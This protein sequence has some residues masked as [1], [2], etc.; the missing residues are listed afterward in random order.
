MKVKLYN[1]ISLDGFIGTNN[2]DV[3]WVSEVDVPYFNAEM[4]RAGCIVIGRKTFE[5]F[6]GNI[7]PVKG[8]L[9]IVMTTATLA[10]S[11]DNNV[12]LPMRPQP[13][14]LNWLKQKD[15]MSYY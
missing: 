3:G 14:W 7:F 15:I 11:K 10:A 13:E 8:V 4:Q 6:Q 9:N 12:L 2:G 1:A 5:Q